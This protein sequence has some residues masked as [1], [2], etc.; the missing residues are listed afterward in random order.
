MTCRACDDR[1]RCRETF[2]C[3]LCRRRL[4]ACAHR[5][6]GLDG[7]ERWPSWCNECWERLYLPPGWDEDTPD[8]AKR[9][10]R[11]ETTWT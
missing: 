4:N 10:R 2:I 3:R 5:V 9:R 11:K 7:C 6:G 8:A 1:S